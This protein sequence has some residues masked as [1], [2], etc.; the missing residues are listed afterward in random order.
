MVDK[1]KNTSDFSGRASS[2][3]YRTYEVYKV[4]YIRENILRLWFYVLY[5]LYIKFMIR[6]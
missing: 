2:I 1:K 3:R 5:K 6:L 4:Y